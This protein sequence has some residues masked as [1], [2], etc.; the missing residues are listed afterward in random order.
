[1]VSEALAALRAA[2]AEAEAARETARSAV[3]KAEIELDLALE[4]EE[5]MRRRAKLASSVDRKKKRGKV[6]TACATLCLL[7]WICLVFLSIFIGTGYDRYIV[8][9]V[10][11]KERESQRSKKREIGRRAYPC[12]R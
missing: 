10:R 5:E 3:V 4:E 7:S 6:A 1:M 9:E 11:V 8:N 2:E 12:R